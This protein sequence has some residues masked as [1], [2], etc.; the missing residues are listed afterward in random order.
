MF[1]L[2]LVLIGLFGVTA[3]SK[4][5]NKCC[6][7]APLNQNINKVTVN[8]RG[9]NSSVR[10]VPV[11]NSNRSSNSYTNKEKTYINQ[12][13]KVVKVP[14]TKIVKL[15][16]VITRTKIK[17]VPVIKTRTKVRTITRTKTKKVSGN[18]IGILV[19]ASKT[20][21]KEDVIEANAKSEI[22]PGHEKDLGLEYKYLFES[23]LGIGLTGTVQ[24]NYYLSIGFNF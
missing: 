2:S 1:K 15:K 8:Q 16:Q 9:G 12:S 24:E 5:S 13:V 20:K 3:Y 17:R 22:R 18:Y 7:K 10:T 21:L 19:G 14:V 4:D 23:G 11:Y 6:Q